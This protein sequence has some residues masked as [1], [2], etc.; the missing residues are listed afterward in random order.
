MKRHLLVAAAV[1]VS[2]LGTFAAGAAD[3][4]CVG[5]ELARACIDENRQNEWWS[6]YVLVD[7][8]V[9]SDTAGASIIEGKRSIDRGTTTQIWTSAGSV[10]QTNDGPT[11]TTGVYTL[12]GTLWHETGPGTCT[13]SATTFTGYHSVECPVPFELPRMN[14]PRI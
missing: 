11:R 2:S 14:A 8:S 5:D 12:A 3:A 6:G 13:L 7:V 9:M 1:A 10:S 4:T